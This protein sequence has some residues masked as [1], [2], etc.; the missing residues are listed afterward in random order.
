MRSV[1][2]ILLSLL[3]LTIG[4]QAHAGERIEMQVKQPN[5]EERITIYLQGEQARIVSTGNTNAAVLFNANSKQLRLIDHQ[6][7]T[8]TKVDQAT[9]E[10]V[11]S[12]AEGVGE[13][14]R[15][16]GGVLGDLFKT[17]GLD[18]AMGEKSVIKHQA[19]AGEYQYSGVS[20]AM[21]QVSK[22]GQAVTNLCL[23][24]ALTLGSAEKNTLSTL[25]SFGQLL[26][27][28][29]QLVVEQFNLSIP[30]LPTEVIKG[31][32]IYVKNIPNDTVATLIGLKQVDIPA[33]QFAVPAG[34]TETVFGF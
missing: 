19:V 12:L 5:L 6:Q 20:C 14:A 27:Q 3:L 25:I 2:T 8:V 9:I 21:Q 29:G 26:V 18:N 16:Q 34:Y 32:P 23:T 31:V 13:I 28:K 17:F 1:S 7:K 33:G 15:S 24:D 11:A 4:Q 22:D 10:Q 30:Q